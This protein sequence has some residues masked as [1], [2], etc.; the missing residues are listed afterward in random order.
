MARVKQVRWECPNGMHPGVLGP[1][2]PRKIATCR[3]CL[4]CSDVAGVLVERVAPANERKRTVKAERRSTAKDRAAASLAERS[5]VQCL[6][7]GGRPVVVNVVEEFESCVAQL[8]MRKPTLTVT[9]RTDWDD[10]RGHAK[11]VE[12]AVHIGA[13]DSMHTKRGSAEALRELILHECVHLVGTETGRKR[14]SNRWHGPK[15]KRRLWEASCERWPEIRGLV[16][17]T[18]MFHTTK[19]Y[20]LDEL[21]IEALKLCAFMDA[22]NE[23]G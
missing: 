17:G 4:K 11:P 22:Q 10:C 12:Y 16:D 19:A 2:R 6:D 13:G 20:D 14:S 7:G 23:E 18:G 3:Y 9:R 21:V 8:G 15:F 5:L 1:S